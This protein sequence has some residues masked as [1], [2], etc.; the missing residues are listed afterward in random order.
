[1]DMNKTQHGGYYDSNTGTTFHTTTSS[2]GQRIRTVDIVVNG[3]S[4]RHYIH[5]RGKYGYCLSQSLTLLLDDM[6]AVGNE[7]WFGTLKELKSAI[8]RMAMV[9]C[10]GECHE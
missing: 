2:Y 6:V 7:Y 9:P 4:M 5:K 3:V 10:K 1:M 8:D